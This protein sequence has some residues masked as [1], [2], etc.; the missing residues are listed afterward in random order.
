MSEAA[1]ISKFWMVWSPTGRAPTYRH[2]TK[3]S[4]Q[5]EATRLANQCPGNPFIVL[6]AVDA[7]RSE[8]VPAAP[9]K[10]TRAKPDS[11]DGIPF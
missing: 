3:K 11:D 2:P 10:I 9:V 1:G 7:Y 8:I 5:D 4:A 6:A